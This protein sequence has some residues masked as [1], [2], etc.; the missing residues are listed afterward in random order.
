M[1]HKTSDRLVH[2]VNQKDGIEPVDG[3]RRLIVVQ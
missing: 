1:H 3:I 2:D